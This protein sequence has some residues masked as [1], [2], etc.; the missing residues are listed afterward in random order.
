MSFEK[1]KWNK[2][3]DGSAMK[4]TSEGPNLKTESISATKG[5]HDRKGSIVNRKTGRLQ[6][7]YVG[8]NSDPG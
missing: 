3:Q 7:F 4:V 6:Q 2:A 1:D 5:P 8:E